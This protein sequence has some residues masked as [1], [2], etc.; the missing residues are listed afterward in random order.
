VEL[1]E[2]VKETKDVLGIALAFIFI[3]LVSL[4]RERLYKLFAKS[5]M[6]KGSAPA[7]PWKTFTSQ[8]EQINNLLIELRAVI[9]ADR[10]YIYQFHNGG[11]FLPNSSAWRITNTFEV[12]GRGIAYQGQNV[13]GVPITRLWDIMLCLFPIEPMNNSRIAVE[14]SITTTKNV[15]VN[16]V[17][18]ILT[19][20]LQLGFAR[21]FLENSHTEVLIL[22][23]LFDE[24]KNIIG[25]LCA[26]YCQEDDYNKSLSEDPLIFDRIN[27]C[28]GLTGLVLSNKAFTVF[29][30]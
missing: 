30:K 22:A 25:C 26:D 17:Y 20:E 2:L 29:P 3:G 18:T 21:N 8:H 12:C 4:F 23:P 11:T 24:K 7:L 16:S 28:A 14:H 10:V 1:L 6:E 15:F 27:S 13:Q 5:T 9:D 19:G